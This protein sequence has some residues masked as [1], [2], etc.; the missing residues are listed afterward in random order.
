MGHGRLLTL[1][2][3]GGGGEFLPPPH[4]FCWITFFCKNRIDLKLFD[5]LSYTYTHPIHLKNLKIFDYS[6]VDNHPKLTEIGKNGKKNGFWAT[7]ATVKQ[8]FS[9][10]L[11]LASNIYVRKSFGEKKI[12][13]ITND[14]LLLFNSLKFCKTSL[15]CCNGYS[16]DFFIA[17]LLHFYDIKYLNLTKSRL[18]NQK[19]GI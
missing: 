14:F 3:V 12:G 13:K 4:Q 9:F 11:W 16:H 6:C 18:S 15:F 8:F 17:V 7:K 5:F 2:H 10:F 1:F 19:S